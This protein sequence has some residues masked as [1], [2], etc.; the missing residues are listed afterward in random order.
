MSYAGPPQVASPRAAKRRQPRA[1]GPHEPQ[2]RPSGG[3]EAAPAAGVGV[4]LSYAGPPQVANCAPSGGSE[5]APAASVGV[6]P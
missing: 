4:H 6:H 2:G 1:W 3:S 5:A